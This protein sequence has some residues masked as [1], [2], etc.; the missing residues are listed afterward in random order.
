MI[1]RSVNIVLIV[2]LVIGAVLMGL[3]FAAIAAQ[4]AQPAPPTVTACEVVNTFGSIE[5]ARCQPENGAA[6]LI[7]SAG[8]MLPTE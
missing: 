8:F 3:S 6:Y 4:A 2:L 7:N 5:I 1:P